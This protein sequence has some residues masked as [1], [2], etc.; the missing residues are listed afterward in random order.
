MNT[1]IISYDLGKPE[2]SSDYAKLIDYLKSFPSWAKPLESFFI[3]KT[4]KSASTVR[5]E[6]LKLID[7]NDRVLILGAT[8]WGVASF[9]LPD[10]FFDWVASDLSLPR[11]AA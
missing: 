8:V 11:A 2:T 5:N 3:V 7:A 9:G 1:L 6:I 10:K 4:E